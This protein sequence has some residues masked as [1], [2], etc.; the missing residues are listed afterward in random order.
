MNT[1]KEYISSQ[2]LI[3]HCTN[4]IITDSNSLTLHNTEGV[5]EFAPDRNRGFQE[6]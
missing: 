6:E 1:M 5:G 3:M 2:M 4:D